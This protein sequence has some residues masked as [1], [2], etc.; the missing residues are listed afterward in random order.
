MYICKDC[1][2][3]YRSAPHL[4]QKPLK[5]NIKMFSVFSIHITL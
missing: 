2:Y 5:D 3:I 4:S 1:I